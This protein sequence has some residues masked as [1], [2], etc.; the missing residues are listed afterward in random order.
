MPDNKTVKKW[1]TND[2]KEIYGIDQWSNDYFNVNNKGEVTVNLTDNGNKSPVS[3]VDI[4]RGLTQRGVQFPVMLRFKDLLES[5]IAH[6]NE[7]F[8]KAMSAVN[9]NG[10]YRGVYPIKVNQQ[11]QVIEEVTRSGEKYHYGLEVGS[12]PELI[13]ALSYMHDPEAYIIC[14]G[15]K[16]SEFISLALHGQQMGLRIVLVIETPSEIDL[17]LQVAKKIKI[18]PLLGIRAKLSTKGGGHWNDSSGD[19][20]VFGLNMSQIIEVIDKIKSKGQINCLRML[21]FHLGSQI[22]DIT[23]LRQGTTEACRIYIDLVKEGAPMGLF[24]IGGGLAVNYGGRKNN[25]SGSSNYDIKE[26]CTDLIEIIKKT[27]D[28]ANVPHPDIISESGRA[29]VAYYSILLFN[30]LDVNRIEADNSL[31]GLPKNHHET[32]DFLIDVYK[33]LKTERL[34][35]NYND[36]VYYRDSLKDLFLHGVISLRELGFTEKIFWSILQK[37]ASA[38]ELEEYVSDELKEIKNT[39]T[40]IYYGNF[41]V[42]QSVPDAW[43]IDQLFPIMPI[44]RLKEEPT[45]EAVISDITCDCDGVINRFVD[46]DG[47]RKTLR[48]HPIISD[49]DY[50]IGIF[51]VGAY[52]E[53]LG[54]LHNLMGDTHVMSINVEKGKIKYSRE[55]E[56]DSIAD[57]LSYAEH[58]PKELLGRFRCLAE[59][60]VEEN[61]VSAT[62][63][64]KIMTAYEAGLRG[65]TYFGK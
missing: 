1:S 19:R 47:E 49:K 62:Q 20:S 14:N 6:L 5:R 12:K 27:T 63:R 17:I 54:D 4:T 38:V 10:T 64:R 41:S 3:L 26:Y 61:L 28:D 59:R 65:Y 40:D 36:A 15:Y 2:S 18:K 48:L 29:I 32:L 39:I 22:T 34:Q 30:V 25:A 21:H 42:F 44:H 31:S 60:A 13:A 33:N 7:S 11:Q 57:V 55:T 9:Y 51:L 35:E 43:A 46:P 53:T 56:G 23:N 37:I 8:L 50:I 45:R 24:N 58:N 16:D 52:Q